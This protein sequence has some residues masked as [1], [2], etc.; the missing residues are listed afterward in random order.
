MAGSPDG[1]LQPVVT[2][3]QK[4]ARQALS[5]TQ[6]GGQHLLG[7]VAL[8]VV[9]VAKA[10]RHAGRHVA[11]AGAQADNGAAGHVLAAVV[12]HALHHRLGKRVA[13]RKALA[14]RGT[15]ASTLGRLLVESNQRVRYDIRLQTPSLSRPQQVKHAAVYL[16]C[17]QVTWS[18]AVAMQAANTP[19]ATPSRAYLLAR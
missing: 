17:R 1:V 6:A 8:H 7:E 11:P 3:D 14:W 10:A 16:S 19:G 13:H 2:V 15:A 9:E 12:A 5:S 4:S 18:Q